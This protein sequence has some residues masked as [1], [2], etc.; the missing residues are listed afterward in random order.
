VRA[1]A[2][3]SL[4]AAG[5]LA[6]KPLFGGLADLLG[7]R[8]AFSV[9]LLLQA[10]GLLGVIHAPGTG[11]LFAVM[12]L[13]GLGIGG[14]LPLS[15]ALLARAF[16][17]ESF[18]PMIGLMMPLLTPLVSAGVPFAAFVFDRTGS[19]TPAFWAFLGALGAAALALGRVRLP[20]AEAL[21]A[22]ASGGAASG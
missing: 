11:A 18:G 9:C 17:P 1:S 4:L 21:R 12:L 13:L 7:E 19:Y 5:A 8:A 2:L 6:G 14:V 20:Q 3:L 10:L 22:P 15:S 16:G